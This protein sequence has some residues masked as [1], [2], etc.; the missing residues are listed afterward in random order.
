MRRLERFA[1]GALLLRAPPRPAEREQRPATLQGQWQ[2]RTQRDGFLE[3]LDCTFEVTSCGG[4]QSLAA[5][6]EQAKDAKAGLA[7][8]LLEAGE[9]RAC[10][11]DASNCG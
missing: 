4:Q 5:Q 2:L 9:D 8:E 1:G 7:G 11:V 10:L 6:S 3:R